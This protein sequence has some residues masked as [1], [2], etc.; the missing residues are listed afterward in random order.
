MQD[1]R[2]YLNLIKQNHPEDFVIVAR[3]VDPAYEITAITVKLEQE[4]KRRPILLFPAPIRPTRTM[5]RLGTKRR[6]SGT[7]RSASTASICAEPLTALSP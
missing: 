1:L 4:A 6:I 2:S 3:E 7:F 5:A